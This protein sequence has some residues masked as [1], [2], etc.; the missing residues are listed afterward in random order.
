MLNAKT[1]FIVNTVNCKKVMGKG[2][3]LQFKNA[4]P[5]M[6]EDYKKHDLKIGKLHIWNNHIINFPTKDDWRNPSKYEYIEDGLHE[7]ARFLKDNPGCSF[8]IPPLGCS[9]GKLN[10]EKICG[11]YNKILYPL[12]L[13]N[14]IYIYLPKVKTKRIPSIQNSFLSNFYNCP[15]IYKDLLFTSS[16]CL[17]QG[18]KNPNELFKFVNITSKQSKKLGRT[19]LIQKNWDKIKSKK[20]YEVLKLKFDQNFDLK[21][22]LLLTGKSFIEETNVWNDKYFGI[23]NNEG[24]NRLGHLLMKLREN[25]CSDL[26]LK[27]YA[28]IGSRETPKEIQNLETKI[29]KKMFLKNWTLTSGNANG[30][31]KAFEYGANYNK[32]IFYSDKFIPEWCYKTVTKYLDYNS[33]WYSTKDYVKGL[34]ARNMQQILG[35]DGDQKVDRVIC[36]TENGDYK[37]GTRYALRCAEDHDIKIINLG[38]KEDRDMMESWVND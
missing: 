10:F 7:L 16:E 36:Y 15:I 19:V 37:G 4:Y 9:N 38:I 32:E 25:Y 2:L 22:K 29:A 12:S 17:Y 21:I 35:Y 8:A 13:I 14:D 28:G 20:M 6:F 31:D 5:K 1:T 27:R 18:F 24:K 34:L 33:N 23:C 30:S 3:A 26:K 11:L